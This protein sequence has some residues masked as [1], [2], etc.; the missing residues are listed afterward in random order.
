MD[1][2]ILPPANNEFMALK[3]SVQFYWEDAASAI[4]VTREYMQEHQILTRDIEVQ[5]KNLS[6]IATS[7]SGLYGLARHDRNYEQYNNAEI[8]FYNQLTGSLQNPEVYNAM[9]HNVQ[10]CLENYLCRFFDAFLD[11]LHLEAN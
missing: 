8:V 4:D 7:C 2:N 1:N 3:H 11:K 6:I 5:L 9:R 10:H